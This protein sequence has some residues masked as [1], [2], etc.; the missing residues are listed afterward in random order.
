MREN[1]IRIWHKLDKQ[2][3]HNIVSLSFVNGVLEKYDN[4]ITEYYIG[5]KDKNKKEIYENDILKHPT[6]GTGIVVFEMGGYRLKNDYGL[7]CN[8]AHAQLSQCRIIGNIHENPE[9]LN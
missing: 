1:K 8:I 4:L 3:V 9:K 7:D 2:Y 6:W 5:L